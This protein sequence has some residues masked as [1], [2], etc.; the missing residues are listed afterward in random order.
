LTV[1]SQDLFDTTSLSSSSLLYVSVSALSRVLKALIDCGASINLINES[2]CSLLSLPVT[3]CRGPRVT[4]ADGATTLS[5]SGIVSF[6]YSIANVSLQDTFFVAPIGVQSM[7]LGMPFLERENPLIDWT[8]KTMEWRTKAPSIPLSLP[9]PLQS[10]T[11]TPSSNVTPVPPTSIMPSE[12]AD[13]VPNAPSSLPSTSPSASPPTSRRRRRLPAILPTRH[14][15]PKRDQLLVF[16]VVDVTELK[17]A[18]E[19]AVDASSDA[20]GV[21]VNAI[22]PS[23]VPTSVPLEYA[24][25]ADVFEEQN[26]EKLP[27]HRPNVDHEI[28]L[29]PGAKPVFGPIYN[30]SE[31]E[32]KVLKDYIDRMLAKG[33][34]R[35]SKSPFGSP[36][37]FVKKADGSLRLVVDYRKLNALT[38]KNR[39]PL[40]LI[41]ELFDRLKNAKY[42]TRLDMQDAYNQLRIALG[43]E[44]KTAFRTRY[45]HYEY[46]VM[47]FGLTNAPASFQA[48]AND[49]LRDFLDL[50]CIVYL[51]DVLIFSE[52]LKEHIAH[53]KQVLSRLRDYELT[54]K[55]KKCEFHATSLSFLGFVISPEGI[56]M[57]SDR[58]IAINEWPIPTNV[59]EIQIFLGFANFYRRFIEGYSRVVSPITLLLR[60]GQRFHWSADC[61]AA[62]EKLKCRFT[63][64]PILKH[65][66]PDYPIRLHT[67]ASGFAISGILSQLHGSTWHPIAFYSRKCSAAECNYDTPDREMLAVVESMRHWRHYLEGSRH[68]IQVLSD[69]KNLEPFMTTKNLNRRQARWAE[70]LANYDFVLVHVPGIKNPADGPSRRPDYAQDVPVP[71]GSLLPLRALRLLPSALRP[72]PSLVSNA[73]FDNLV[74]LQTALAIEPSLRERILASLPSDVGVQRYRENPTLPWS[75]QDGLLLRNGLV[76]IPESLCVDVIQEHHDLPLIG[77]PGVA[78]TCELITRN[79]WF[80]R[81][82]RS[83][84]NYINSC[85]LCQ[86][87]KAPRHAKHGELAPLPV[88]TSPWKGLSCDFITDLPLSNGMDSILVFVDR[89]TKMSHFVPCLKSTSA[90]EFARLFISHVVRLHGLSDSIVSDRGSIFTSN[91]WST[92]ASILKIDPRKSTAFHPQTDGQTERMNQTLETYLRIFVNHEQNDWFDLLP[93]AEF[94]YNNA[95]QESTRMSPFYANY[96]FHPRFLAEFANP[97]TPIP[98]ANDFASHLQ[99]VHER[100][101]ENIKKAQDYQAHYYDRKHKP[102]EFKPGDLVWLNSSHISTMRPSKKLDWK[103][104][105]PFKVLERIGLQA[106]RLDLP[107]TMRHIH[108]VFHVSLLEQYKSSSLPPHGLPPPLPPLY[109]KDD[110]KYFEIEKILDSRRIGNRVQYLI[111]WKGYPDSDNSWEPLTNI[112]ARGLIKEFHRRN[113][114]KPG[115]RPRTRA[116]AI[117]NNVNL[118]PLWYF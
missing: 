13:P 84:E 34:I 108:N 52:T 88:P 8:A 4:L 51:D 3:P 91:F 53:V 62:F 90:P 56:S 58:V 32:L 94:A 110:H 12:C 78:R 19:A 114:N 43:D 18:V 6:R 55:L 20:S 5:C 7:I 95:R 69:H 81:M 11:V 73:L 92:L 15:N 109:I 37:L 45:G 31:T 116:V 79:F 89:M 1:S 46:L 42:Y 70:L 76:Y 93:L 117:I 104:L 27:P 67:D 96:G 36:I 22:P 100:L 82:Q 105:G 59:E 16:T 75:L 63:S 80:P 17:A 101:V 24:E 113:P 97:T 115:S 64:A 86:T 83:V 74:G 21:Q 25:Y 39:Y 10:S 72:M 28:P 49:C 118:Q 14:I 40:P 54:C 44:W 30:L 112:P 107:P 77:H 41:S 60:K 35:P 9:P 99:E 57:N 87:S 29:I 61:Q 98:A 106:Y 23:N 71:T 111:K 33:W 85:H 38:V 2:L 50:F 68:P 47:P 102:V 66:D 65:F 103:R 48:Y 26:A